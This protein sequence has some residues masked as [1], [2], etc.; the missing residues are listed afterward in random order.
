MKLVEELQKKLFNGKPGYYS[1]FEKSIA[2][3]I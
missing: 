3:A 1:Y 2:K